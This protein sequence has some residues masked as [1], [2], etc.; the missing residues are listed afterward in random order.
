MAING[1]YSGLPPYPAEANSQWT[2]ICPNCKSETIDTLK[3]NGCCSYKWAFC[4]CIFLCAGVCVL[5]GCCPCLDHEDT[6][7]KCRE[8]KTVVSK[9]EE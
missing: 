5:G 8:C 1:N 2:L 6:L 7:K 4:C 3:V 9:T